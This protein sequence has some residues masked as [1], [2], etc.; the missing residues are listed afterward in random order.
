M[1]LSYAGST[2]PEGSEPAA[3]RVGVSVEPVK[4][5]TFWV[6][7]VTTVAITASIWTV[8]PPRY[9]TNDDVAIR[10]GVE[11]GLVPGQPPT[12]YVLM[13]HSALAW[14][15]ANLHQ[16]LP[17]M[18]LWDLVVVG[19]LICALATLFALCWPA[20]G[21]GWL[22]RCAAVASLFA[23][24]ASLLSGV[25]FTMSA[26]AA[27][28]A[29]VALILAEVWRAAGRRRSIAALAGLLLVMGILVR[30]MAAI[31]GAIATAAFFVPLAAADPAGRR[32]RLATLAAT[33]LAALIAFAALQY[34]DAALYGLDSRWD[35]YHRSNWVIASV[36]EW[37]LETPSHDPAVREPVQWTTNDWNLLTT[38][39]GVDPVLH[40]PDRVERAYAPQSGALGW[41]RR[42]QGALGKASA[43]NST[44]IA[45]L[46]TQSALV[47][48]VI[49]TLMLARARLSGTMA[50]MLAVSIFVIYCVA[51]EA[52]FKV[53]PLRLLAPLQVCLTVAAVI[54]IGALR[55][56]PSP[57]VSVLGVSVVVALAIYQ[58]EL[59]LRD[60]AADLRHTEQVEKEV[61]ELAAAEPSLL[62]LHLDA[63]P[64]EHWWRPFRHP[65]A[66]LPT[67][68]LGGNNQNPQLQDFLSKTGRQPLLRAVCQDPSIIVVAHPERLLP[69]TI[70]M[71]EHYDTAVSWTQVREGSLRAW[72]CAPRIS[73]E[74]G[75]AMPIGPSMRARLS[76]PGQT[77]D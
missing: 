67:V 60:L 56:A 9:L 11:G 64:S 71:Q 20:F 19:V 55:R 49:G 34:V 70:Y 41:A 29:A 17:A 47:L 6:A 52:G 36:N 2:P 46:V 3:N 32:W 18:P 14:T 39:W 58:A 28:G 30:P 76:R 24:A 62:V 15:L 77:Q 8:F 1:H 50:A 57:V 13:S 25:Q 33:G 65:P 26:T 21:T 68:R 23:A 69:A 53:V 66:A 75:A 45:A 22:A 63:F 40:A 37:N 72:R 27:G 43:V 61:L 4:W 73:T 42:L 35:A 12:G 48:A 38:G 16:L 54:S 44:Q 51:V 7:M 31:A 10:L 59:V 5:R 74:A